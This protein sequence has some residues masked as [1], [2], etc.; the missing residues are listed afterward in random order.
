MRF[1]FFP[2]CCLK[3]K[4]W[5]KNTTKIELAVKNLISLCKILYMHMSFCLKQRNEF[6]TFLSRLES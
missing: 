2:D 5:H 1:L 3:R 6:F 4:Y